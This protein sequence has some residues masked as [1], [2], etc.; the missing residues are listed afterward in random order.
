MAYT[1][2]S[3]GSS[4][5]YDLRKERAVPRRNRKKATNSRRPP[6]SEVAKLFHLPL[7]EVV[8]QL[9]ICGAVVKRICS[10]NG[11]HRW[12]FR[13]V[14]AA[15]KRSGAFGAAAAIMV[16]SSGDS[17]IDS[18]TVTTRS[19]AAEFDS[20]P[21]QLVP[22]QAKSGS[23]GSPDAHSV[24]QFED[25]AAKPLLHDRPVAS[26]AKTQP[27]GVTKP[28]S[29]PSVTGGS[30]METV[31]SCGDS[32]VAYPTPMRLPTLQ[33]YPFQ[34][35]H[36]PNS[37]VTALPPLSTLIACMGVQSVAGPAPVRY[38]SGMSE[39]TALFSSPYRSIAPTM[40]VPQRFW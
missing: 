13:K 21:F 22:D 18:P 28:L 24:N 5:D 25:S 31:S 29:V 36:V 4:S 8:R 17:A 40:P 7:K 30:S 14:E 23:P 12:P 32:P 37:A 2:D 35:L 15:R 11:I 20:T 6:F 26:V 27:S 16:L 10:E 3:D 1:S 19:M 33:P 34:Q 39:H 38:V 9:G